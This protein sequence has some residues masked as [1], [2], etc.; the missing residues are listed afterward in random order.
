MFLGYT[1]RITSS[2]GIKLDSSRTINDIGHTRL[3]LQDLSCN[4]LLELKN[5][6]Y[7]SI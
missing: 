5:L 4:N 6:S 7:K 2:L 1:Y 3:E